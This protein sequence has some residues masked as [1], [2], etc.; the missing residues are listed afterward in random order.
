VGTRMPRW[1][2]CLYYLALTA[3]YKSI[4][5]RVFGE[6]YL[7][8]LRTRTHPR[9]VC[10]FH[11]DVL[12]FFP[13]FRG[14]DALIFTTA[15]KRG[16]YVAEVIR[17]F[18]YRPSKIPDIRGRNLALDAM[19]AEIRKGNSAVLVVDGPL[20]P[21]HKVKHGALVLARRTG[22]PIVPMGSASAWRMVLKKRWDRYV[23]PFPFTRAAIVI[24]APIS[25]PADAGPEQLEALRLQ[26]EERLKGVNRTA[27]DA[28]NRR[29]GNPAV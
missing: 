29:K 1:T 17:R 19:T 28:L 16:E 20:G 22:C 18:G 27:R 6:E 7:S 12:L 2:A 21:Y 4:R 10:F 15:S 3:L 8:D 11:G 14:C 24:G 25:V 13:H 26:V 9:I 23:I 5:L